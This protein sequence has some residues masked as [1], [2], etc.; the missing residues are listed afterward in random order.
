MLLSIRSAVHIPSSVVR[1]TFPRCKLIMAEC[2]LSTSQPIS[3]LNGSPLATRNAIG[4]VTP[5]LVSSNDTCFLIVLFYLPVAPMI[6]T[7]FIGRVGICVWLPCC[8]LVNSMLSIK[9]MF[10]PVSIIM[11]DCE[12]CIRDRSLL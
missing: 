2:C 8:I 9:E 12:M 3:I 7:L 6:V 10:D 4:I 1:D 5:W 11:V